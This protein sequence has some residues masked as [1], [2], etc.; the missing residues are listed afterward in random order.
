MEDAKLLAAL[1]ALCL[2]WPDVTE[3]VTFGANPTFKAGRKTFAV[4]DRYK[5]VRCLCVRCEGP[6]RAR[7]LRD[8]GAYFAPPYD[9]QKKWIALRCD[10]IAR[11][12][13]FKELCIRSYQSVA[14]PP[15]LAGDARPAARRRKKSHGHGTG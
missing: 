14:G 8:K 10:S 9:P 7:L 12:S 11:V 1:R 13:D 3:T 2:R 4:V 5:G 6:E 15:P